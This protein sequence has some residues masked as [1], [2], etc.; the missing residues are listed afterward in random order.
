[1]NVRSSHMS[2]HDDSQFD[3]RFNKMFDRKWRDRKC[4]TV[5]STKGFWKWKRTTME[6]MIQLQLWSSHLSNSFPTELFM[7]IMH[8]LLGLNNV[9]KKCSRLF[10]IYIIIVYIC[11][12][13]VEFSYVRVFRTYIN[14][15][16]MLYMWNMSYV[17]VWICV[18]D[19]YAISCK[20]NISQIFILKQNRVRN[21]YFMFLFI[22]SI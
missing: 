6:N 21:F 18:T 11:I 1:M 10:S 4:Y 15:Y 19:L 14:L 2:T 7:N 20:L 16:R 12:N 22:S 9:S 5:R 3:S 17:Y 8:H 13:S